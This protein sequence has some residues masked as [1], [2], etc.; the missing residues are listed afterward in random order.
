MSVT[1]AYSDLGLD[2]TRAPLRSADPDLGGSELDLA[3]MRGGLRPTSRR[4]MRLGPA[5]GY[6]TAE[7]SGATLLQ[8]AWIES[9]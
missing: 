3:R 1:P 5:A 7:N 6:A 2:V 9:R 4:S 8:R